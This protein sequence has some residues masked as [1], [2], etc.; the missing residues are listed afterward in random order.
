MWSH[1]API[2]IWLVDGLGWKTEEVWPA[3]WWRWAAGR[4]PTQVS[5][6]G[7]KNQAKPGWEKEAKTRVWGSIRW[8]QVSRKGKRQMS[9]KAPL[10]RVIDTECLL[11]AGNRTGHQGINLLIGIKTRQQLLKEKADN[12]PWHKGDTQEALLLEDSGEGVN[13]QWQ[14]RQ[15][16]LRRK[17]DT[18]A[19]SRA[20]TKVPKEERSKM[21]KY[22]YP[23]LIWDTGR[24]KRRVVLIIILAILRVWLNWI[25]GLEPDWKFRNQP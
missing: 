23:G 6:N 22:K 21:C 10:I 5:V 18:K 24:Q 9:V 7:R 25:A 12:A 16:R 1:L 3:S 15:R 13:S 4:T 20:E 2:V 11:C 14:T 17:D 19:L 8:Q